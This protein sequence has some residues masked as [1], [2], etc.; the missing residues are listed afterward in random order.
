M[1]GK[2]KV[3]LFNRSF[4]CDSEF[5]KF[6]YD[7]N[8]EFSIIKTHQTSEGEK[9]YYRCKFEFYIL[10]LNTSQKVSY[11]EIGSHEHSLS[12]NS[13]TSSMELI[14]SYLTTHIEKGI[15]KPTHLL[16][17]IQIFPKNFILSDGAYAQVR[18]QKIL[19]F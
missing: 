5:E 3:W 7:T 14:K 9:I 15:T 11:Y 19:N 2:N 13:P 6:I 4:S 10:R 1:K 8:E 18:Q 12:S 17:Y 16:Q